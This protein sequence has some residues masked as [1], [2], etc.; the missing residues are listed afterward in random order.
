V[1]Y[2]NLLTR[3]TYAE[4]RKPLKRLSVRIN[5]Y[6]LIVYPEDGENRFAFFHNI[7]KLAL[8]RTK[9]HTRKK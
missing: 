7:G 5:M 9:S 3:C 6:Y 4:T 1:V 2:F 8:D